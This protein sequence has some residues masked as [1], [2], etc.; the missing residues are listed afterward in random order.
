[1]YL[2]CKSVIVPP[3]Q[4]RN[5]NLEG[6]QKPLSEARATEALQAF[7]FCGQKKKFL[8]W[9]VPDRLL[10]SDGSLKPLGTPSPRCW[11]VPEDRRRW[12]PLLEHLKGSYRGVVATEESGCTSVPFITLDPDRH[13][14]EDPHLHISNVFRLGRLCQKL[15]PQ[16]KWL[17]EVNLNNGSTKFFG[18]WR[19]PIPIAQ[20]RAMAAQLYE[21]AK[22][23]CGN[24][25]IEAF[26]YNCQQ[27]MLPCRTDKMTIINS[28]GL[29]KCERYKLGSDGRE[30]YTTYSMVALSW[31]FPR[32]V[33][34]W[35]RA[36][37]PL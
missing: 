30:Y 10:Q 6:I 37:H 34:A 15:F 2:M 23:I 26:P 1:M 22:E 20:A 19:R 13:H 18:F 9:H 5:G 33:G 36:Y 35:K 25:K 28:G 7:F 24:P 29:P 27:V 32:L 31:T 12:S 4:N 17:V 21:R 8:G 11:A 3:I 14:G 16:L